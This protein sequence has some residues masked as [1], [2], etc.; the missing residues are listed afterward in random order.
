MTRQNGRRHP[1][2]VS[3]TDLAKMGQ[4]ELMIA[5]N[6]QDDRCSAMQDSSR[7]GQAEHDRYHLRAVLN[8]G[9]EEEAARLGR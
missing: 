2:S 3:A 1:R 8:A 9:T 6:I 4:C 7:R 5:L